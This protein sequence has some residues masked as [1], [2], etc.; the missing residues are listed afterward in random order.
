VIL[1][2]RSGGAGRAMFDP[3]IQRLKEIGTPGVVLSGDRDEGPLLGTV[4]PSAQPPGRGRLVGRRGDA[5]LVQL[6]W[7]SPPE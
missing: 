5:Q 1:A 3:I 7:L 2:R 6:A 4:R